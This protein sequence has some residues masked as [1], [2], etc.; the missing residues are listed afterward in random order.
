MTENLDRFELGV[1]VG[2]V[3]DFTWDVFCDW[4]IEVAKLRL[5]GE[6]EA[7]KQGCKQVLVYVMTGILKL[8]HPF[9]PF[10]TEEIYSALPHSEESIM[11]SAWPT[12]HEEL[13]FEQDEQDFSKIMDLIRAVRV[14]RSGMNVPPSK[15]AK[16]YIETQLSGVFEKGVPFI[17][18][19]ASA[20]EVV[21]GNSFELDDAA[22]TVTDSARILIPMAELVD[23]DK[24]L[25]RLTKE[26]A[27]VVKDF[28]GLS[29]RLANENFVNKAPANVVALE[30]ERL[31][32]L[33]DKKALIEASIAKLK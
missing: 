27:A 16:M 17:Q 29:A 25:A 15:R 19:L 18:R 23:K 5:T 14:L 3:Y 21:I 6:D 33:E 30:R 12:F 7:A 10:I 2:K 8:L 13:V 32:K 31:G 11:I 4:Y 28:T 20:D 24:E 22:Q 26:L 1:A 9:M